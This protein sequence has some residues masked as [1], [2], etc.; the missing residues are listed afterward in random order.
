MACARTIRY[1]T[2]SFCVVATLI[3]PS[4]ASAASPPA[5]RRQCSEDDTSQCL[6]GVGSAVVAPDALRVPTSR[7]SAGRGGR[8]AG[9]VRAF[10]GEAPGVQAAPDQAGLNAGDVFSLGGFAFWTAYGRSHFEGTS[11]NTPYS[12]DSSIYT[13][14]ADRLFAD[15]WLLGLTV[16]YEDTDTRTFYNGGGQLSDGFGVAPYAVLAITD[17]LSLD[18]AGGVTWT[19]TDQ[20]RI[21]L[22]PT[23]GTERIR[24]AF[25]AE[26]WFGTLNLNVSQDYGLL[27][28]SGRA[29][30]LFL[31]ETQDAYTETGTGGAGQVLRP[32]SV[33]ER[34]VSL[35]QAYAGAELAGRFERAMPYLGALYRNDV[36][37]EDGASAGGLPTNVGQTLTSDRDEVELTAGVRWFGDSVTGSVEYLKTL[38]RKGFENDS[39]QALLRLAL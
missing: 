26:R 29:G 3:G 15:R 7:H 31:E 39:F 4:V 22:R 16:S 32:R 11:A 30:Y 33:A 5:S 14:G 36:S 12:A 2:L 23:G 17:F 27:S 21:G 1:S 24:S 20:Q 38:D 6:N 8:G 25:D 9:A 28:L 10:S 18:A 13:L 34:R 19:E 37:R 35:G